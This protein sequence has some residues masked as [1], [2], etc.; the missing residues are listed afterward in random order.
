M[1]NFKWLKLLRIQ[2]DPLT[3]VESRKNSNKTWLEKVNY[4]EIEKNKFI[5]NH[6]SKKKS[7]WKL[8]YFE[9]D[10]DE[11]MIYQNLRHAAF[12]IEGG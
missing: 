9:L 4:Q 1:I 6:V 7:H 11:D 10:D 8:K 5:D 2:I 3:S 12:Y